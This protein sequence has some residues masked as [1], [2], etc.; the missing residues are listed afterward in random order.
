MFL[1]ID[2]KNQIQKK[3]QTQNIR[4]LDQTGKNILSENTFKHFANGLL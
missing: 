2:F 3:V 4:A 1:H